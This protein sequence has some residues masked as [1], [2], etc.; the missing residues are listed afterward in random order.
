MDLNGRISAW[1]WE[2]LAQRS[3]DRHRRG[4]DDVPVCDP[5]QRTRPIDLLRPGVGQGPVSQGRHEPFQRGIAPQLQGGPSYRRPGPLPRRAQ[6]IRLLGSAGGPGREHHHPPAHPQFPLALAR[7]HPKRR[8]ESV[9][10]PRGP[11]RL[12]P[13]LHRVPGHGLTLLPPACTLESLG[14]AAGDSPQAADTAWCR[15][16]TGRGRFPEG[17]HSGRGYAA[18]R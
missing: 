7:D 11:P 8:A 2:L 13:L 14:R 15:P 3:A 17:S 12:Q 9:D 18:P 1:P 10:F 5:T 6:D 16:C 4:I